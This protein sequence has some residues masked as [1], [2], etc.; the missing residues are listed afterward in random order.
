M[1]D[2]A[3]KIKSYIAMIPF[4]DKMLEIA[5]SLGIDLYLVGGCI[6]DSFLDRPNNDRDIAVTDRVFDFSRRLADE[7]GSSFVTLDKEFGIARVVPRSKELY[8]DFALTRGGIEDDL[9]R[10][11]FTINAMAANLR[12]CEVLDPS[13]GMA[14]LENQLVRSYSRQN[15]TDDPLRILRAYRMSAKLGFS[16]DPRTQE[17]IGAEKERLPEI[18]FERI[19]DEIFKIMKDPHSG[20][21]IRALYR[22]GILGILIPELLLMEGMDQNNFHKFDVLEHSLVAY[23]EVEKLLYEAPSTLPCRD[24]IGEYLNESI[25][26]DRIRLQAMK[27]AV[28]LHDIGKPAVRRIDHN[29]ILYYK[30]HHTEGRNIWNKIS[31]R[32]KL[33]NKEKSLG[34]RMIERHLEPV[35]IP[36]KDHKTQQE[37]LYDFYLAAGDAAVGVILLS[38]GDVEAGQGEALKQNL[39]DN[40][41]NFSRGMIRDYFG[42][43]PIAHPPQFI[44]G[45]D[46]M[47]LLNLESGQE[48]GRLMEILRKA[49]ALEQIKSRKEAVELVGNIA[50]ID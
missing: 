40:H 3:S 20:K 15:I 32:F 16:I 10:R 36:L 18:S 2:K 17:W 4:R 42:K 50:N 49:S 7:T 14:D 5:D 9:L 45:K 28:L 19:R 33:S 25:A 34:G 43:A 8:L 35:F 1:P 46:V 39:I 26:G 11:D 6:R 37:L 38:W 44:N 30:G 41:H 24:L 23:D 27:F 22:D 12:N 29:G 31:D 47:N 48:I 13:G 21:Y